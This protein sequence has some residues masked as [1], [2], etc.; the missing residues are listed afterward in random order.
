LS[1]AAARAAIAILCIRV[2]PGLF[3]FQAVSAMTPSSNQVRA[4]RRAI[5]E[6]Q[7]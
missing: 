6:A 7:K 4:V 2:S 5:E 1:I 3:R